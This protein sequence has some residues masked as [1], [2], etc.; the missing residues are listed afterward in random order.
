MKFVDPTTDIAFKKVFGS[1]HRKIVLIEFLN[2]VL[3]LDSPIEDVTL[4]NPYQAPPLQ[5]L[6]PTTLDVRARDALGREFIVEMQVEKETGFH[7]RV[8]YYT[9]KAYVQ[10]LDVGEKY[11]LLRP[12]LFLG[13]LDFTIFETSGYLTR[14]LILNPDTG[15]RTLTDFEFNFIELPKFPKEEAELRT[16]TEQWIYFLKNVRNLEVIPA[17]ATSPGLVEAYQM[18]NRFGWTREELDIYEYQGIQRAKQRD[19]FETASRESYEKGLADGRAAG[20]AEGRHGAL[21]ETAQRL[22]E[23]GMIPENVAEITGMELAE[24]L[25]ERNS[26]SQP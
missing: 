26:P 14:H 18:A 15:E 22:L 12:V 20:R 6:K 10:Q 2:N 9:S 3:D 11:H 13:V 17:S 16:P 4:L 1:E 8:L 21:W 23:Y 19:Q 7:K 24:L 25:A 5:G